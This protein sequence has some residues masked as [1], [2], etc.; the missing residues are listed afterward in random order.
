M[1]EERWHVV[2]IGDFREHESRPSCWCHPTPD[3]D[4][5]GVWVHHSMDRREEYEE[6]RK[7]Q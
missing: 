5:P 7:K 6:G 4:D 3:E 2:P 1:S